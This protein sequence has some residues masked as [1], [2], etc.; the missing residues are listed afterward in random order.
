MKKEMSLTN[1]MYLTLGL[2]KIASIVILEKPLIILT[3]SE[4]YTL[5]VK[6]LFK[7]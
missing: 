7:P 2:S 3:Y 5:S 6:D 4:W 1:L